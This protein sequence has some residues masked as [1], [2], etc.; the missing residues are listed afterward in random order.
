MR[1]MELLDSRW[2][3]SQRHPR[4]PAWVDVEDKDGWDLKM[5]VYAA[6]ID[7]MDQNIGRLL[8]KLHQLGK[9]DNT[10]VLFLSDNGAC[11]ED[12]RDFD[13]EESDIPPGPMESYRTVDLPWANASDT[14]FRK[15]KQWTHEG[16]IATP[17]IARWPKVIEG[18]GTLTHQVGHVMDIMPTLCEVAGANY[19]ETYNDETVLPTEGKSLLPVFVGE[20][21]EAHDVICWE[22]LGNRA[23]RQGKWKIVAAK[24]ESWE[25]YDLDENRSETTNLAGQFPD[26]VERMAG[27]WSDW[28]KRTG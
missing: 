27:M 17:L 4:A 1:E 6:M 13:S 22:H 21:R 12:A 15:F 14:P 11:A 8:Q 9:E 2:A 25:L 7:S 24:G 26:K 3:L 23:V 10:L 5:A 28:A 16:G 20:E 19:P 18:G